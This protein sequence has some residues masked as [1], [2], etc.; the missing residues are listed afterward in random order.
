MRGEIV[1]FAN[2]QKG[3]VVGVRFASRRHLRNPV[4]AF[5]QISDE[6]RGIGPDLN[7]IGIRVHDITHSGGKLGYFAG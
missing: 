7:S 5:R 2:I 4:R 6:R 3:H 1:L